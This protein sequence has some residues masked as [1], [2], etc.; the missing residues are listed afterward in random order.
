MYHEFFGLSK[1]PFNMTPDPG[2]LF[3]TPQHREAL[4]GL[5]YAILGKKGFLVLTGEAGTGK[6]T[7]LV[8]VLQCLPSERIQSSVVLNPTLTPGEFLE[9]ALM[10]FGVAEVPAGKPQRLAKLQ[11]LLLQAE[12]RN[13]ICALVVDEAHKLSPEILEEIR[14]LGNFERSD[15]KLMQI[16]LLGQNELA[17]LLNR[18]DMRQLKQ[19]IATRFSLAPLNA[20]EVGEY[21]RHRWIKAGGAPGIPFTPDSVAGIA[22]Y[23][24]GVPR[25]INAICDNALM[26]A[27]GEAMKTVQARHVQEGCRDLDLLR[28]DGTG[29][30]PA[31]V[32]N[33]VRRP[34]AAVRSLRPSS[35]P[36]PNRSI[37]ARWAGKLGLATHTE[38]V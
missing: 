38:Y 31:Y 9:M 6:T 13:K 2:F 1:S 36:A 17:D 30:K 28:Q 4:A 11:E 5:S 27:F 14:L 24:R 32:E 34:P 8:R 21:I 15:H 16:L 33:P 29:S 35:E 22:Q 3:L 23:S 26:L 37:L 18:P 7:L 25:V 20:G 10:G 19:R 12:A